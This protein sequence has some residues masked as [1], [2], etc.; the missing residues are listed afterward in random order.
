MVKASPTSSR[1]STVNDLVKAL[2]EAVSEFLLEQFELTEEVP[3]GLRRETMP[4]DRKDWQFTPIER[5][6]LMV[7]AEM[8]REQGYP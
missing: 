1:S 3:E 7:L 2:R 5:E 6:G 4:A 8:W